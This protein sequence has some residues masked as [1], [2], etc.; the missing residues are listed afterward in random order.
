MWVS[1]PQACIRPA[2][3]EREAEPGVLVHRQRI[4]V[5]TQQH[6]APWPGPAQRG[7]RAGAR[8]ASAP[9]ERQVGQLGADF[10]ESQRGL[11]PELGLGVDRAAQG[12]DARR[13]V[14]AAAR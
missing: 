5:A 6:A 12:D 14:R 3:A 4:H 8:G 10:G 2:I 11:E 7:D 13:D 9:F 1:S